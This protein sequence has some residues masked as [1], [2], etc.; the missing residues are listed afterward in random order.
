M[1][2]RSFRGLINTILQQS[3]ESRRNK[4]SIIRELDF[5]VVFSFLGLVHVFRCLYLDK[6]FIEDESD[7]IDKEAMEDDSN[8]G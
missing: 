1:H 3:H 4:I 6:A 7:W 8:I 5:L 2:A